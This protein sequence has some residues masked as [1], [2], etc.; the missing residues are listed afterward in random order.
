MKYPLYSLIALVV[1]IVAI[2]LLLI[3]GDTSNGEVLTI[4]SVMLANIPGLV[5][6]FMAERNN[7]AIQNGTL[8]DKA[9]QG[10]TA[11]L[12]ETGVTEAVKDAPI[13]TEGIVKTM[14]AHSDALT[15]ILTNW[16]TRGATPNG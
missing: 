1:F 3:F 15:Q 8:V 6:A 13:T 12:S 14:N 4:I 11:A 9:K 2:V 5:A 10:A 16:Q 7:N